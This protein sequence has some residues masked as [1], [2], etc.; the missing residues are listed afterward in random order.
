MQ[1]F[2]PARSVFG[3]ASKKGG[4][5]FLGTFLREAQA[6]HPEMR[7][8]QAVIFLSLNLDGKGIIV[9]KLQWG[10]FKYSQATQVCRKYL[11][12]SFAC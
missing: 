9:Q 4:R 5:N 12:K 11:Q 2:C 6:V 8:S 1:I 10:C 7:Q 3:L